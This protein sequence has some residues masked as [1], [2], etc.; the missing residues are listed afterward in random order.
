MGNH[1]LALGE[2]IGIICPVGRYGR[3]YFGT[4]PSLLDVDGFRVFDSFVAQYSPIN[5]EGTVWDLVPQSAKEIVYPHYRGRFE[6]L[7]NNIFGDITLERLRVPLS[8]SNETCII[9]HQPG[10]RKTQ[11]T[12][13]CLRSFL[14]L[15]TQYRL[16]TI[17][18]SNLILN[19]EDELKNGRWTSFC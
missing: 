9:S 10:T 1:H 16:V 4:S 18:P 5:G 14:K 8:E 19:R 12:I 7:W 11:I 6:C 3:K 17:A 2:Q 15:F 13:V